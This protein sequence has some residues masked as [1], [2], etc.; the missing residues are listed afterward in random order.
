[1]GSVTA[2]LNSAAFVRNCRHRIASLTPARSAI[3]RVVT[4]EKPFSPN[5]S[6]AAPTSRLRT[7]SDERRVAR[8][9]F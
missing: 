2:T 7:S 8:V 3:W 1:M 6:P 4:P 9:P 5:S